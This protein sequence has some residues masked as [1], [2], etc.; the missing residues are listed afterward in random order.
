MVIRDEV[1]G[2]GIQ[3]LHGGGDQ[4]PFKK[5]GGCVMGTYIG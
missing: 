2:H 4:E 3:L 1:K 5:A